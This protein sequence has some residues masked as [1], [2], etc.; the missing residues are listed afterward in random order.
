MIYVFVQ[1]V[2]VCQFFGRFGL[3]FLLSIYD[4]VLYREDNHHV[5]LDIVPLSQAM[6]ASKR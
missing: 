6:P 1:R 5:L 2:L 4:I 3:L